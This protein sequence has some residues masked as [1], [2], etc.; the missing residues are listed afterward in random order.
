[1]RPCIERGCG[2]LVQGTRCPAHQ[3]VYEQ[4]RGSAAARGYDREWQMLV[5]QMKAEHVARQGWV[6]PGW[7]VPSHPSG[8]LTGDHRVP[9]SVGGQSVRE[10]VVILCRA[11]N[12][13]K[14]G[15]VGGRD[16]SVLGPTDGPATSTRTLAAKSGF[17][18]A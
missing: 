6:C 13:R 18:I 12:S 10:N 11:C 15:T 2:V 1:M 8:D 7:G 16:V 17:W 14:G 3:R 9:L 4:R 5:A